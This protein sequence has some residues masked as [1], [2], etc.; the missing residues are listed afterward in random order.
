M[1]VIKIIYLCITNNNNNNKYKHKICLYYCVSEMSL[2]EL[3][4]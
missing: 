4:T 3:K 2:I 1:L